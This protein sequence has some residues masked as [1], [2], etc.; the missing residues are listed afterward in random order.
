MSTTITPGTRAS[1]QY[2]LPIAPFL[3]VVESLSVF[4]SS[5]TPLAPNVRVLLRLALEDTHPFF[6]QRVFQFDIRSTHIRAPS[7]L[8]RMYTKVFSTMRFGAG[9]SFRGREA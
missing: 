3:G 2:R 1:L 8:L 7:L 9:A 5:A 6:N 4:P